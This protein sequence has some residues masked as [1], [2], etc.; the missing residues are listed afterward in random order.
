[1]VR[2]EEVR[3]VGGARASRLRSIGILNA[4]MLAQS[5]C[6]DLSHRAKLDETLCRMMVVN[7]LSLLPKYSFRNG[8][9]IHA[10]H[11]VKDHIRTGLDAL[12]EK[13][14]GG[15]EMGSLVEFYGPYRSGKTNL[16]H[17]LAV[18]VQKD[19]HGQVIWI[20][21]DGTFSPLILRMI[22]SRM[23]MEPNECL[24]RVQVVR[25]A[26]RDHLLSLLDDIPE[27]VVN[28]GPTLV[29]LD[30]ISAFL[31]DEYVGLI[32]ARDARSELNQC[33]L[34]LRGLTQVAKAT[35]LYTSR[36]FKDEMMYG[37]NLNA[38][39]GGHILAFASDYRFM[40]HR[41]REEESS[42]KLLDHVALPSME[43]RVMIGWGGLYLTRSDKIETERRVLQA[44]SDE[45]G[46][47]SEVI[48]ASY[49]QT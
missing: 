10:E 31:Q 22:A 14:L 47:A 8:M 39:L 46:K 12:D 6:Y 40:C 41:R 21:A 29:I 44:I 18:M 13:L 3:G 26:S 9:A 25:V 24:E 37:T 48:R 27:I 32:E 2:L 35:V 11:I 34:K 43:W 20:D 42:I 5:S 1:M 38:P 33:I 23:E 49:V 16:C 28:E 7:A 19:Y 4:E 36:V 30:S 45:E 17:Q 15:I